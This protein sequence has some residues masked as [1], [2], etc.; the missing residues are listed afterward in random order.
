MCIQELL[1]WLRSCSTRAGG[2][3]T[4]LALR[5]K[6]KRIL[7]IKTFSEFYAAVHLKATLP[8]SPDKRTKIRIFERILISAPQPPLPP[9]AEWKL[10]EPAARGFDKTAYLLLHRF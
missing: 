3:S 8:P 5:G 9:I 4:A 2:Y 10:K 1:R 6:R 7:S